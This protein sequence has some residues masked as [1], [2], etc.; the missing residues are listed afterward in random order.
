MKAMPSDLQSD[1]FDRLGISPFSVRRPTREER[2]GSGQLTSPTGT[3]PKGV[4]PM[5][6]ARSLLR[7]NPSTHHRKT[8]SAD[9]AAAD[10]DLPRS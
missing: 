1:P 8:M 3:T 2:A 5:G 7:Q 6:N 9:R 10:A 4:T